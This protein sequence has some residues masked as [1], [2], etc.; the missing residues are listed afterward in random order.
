[1]ACDERRSDARRID[2]RRIVA[3]RIVARRIV[4]RRIVARR[5]VALARRGFVRCPR[6]AGRRTRHRGVAA[7]VLSVRSMRRRGCR[8][9]V[10]PIAHRPRQHP[11]GSLQEL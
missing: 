11:D 9:A 4:A 2:A 8:R 1:V 10:G 3:R 6:A 7:G 5:I